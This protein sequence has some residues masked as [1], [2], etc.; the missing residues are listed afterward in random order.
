MAEVCWAPTEKGGGL[1]TESL[2]EGP[3]QE[4]SYYVLSISL[5]T[6]DQT[7]YWEM[8]MQ[9]LRLQTKPLHIPAQNLYSTWLETI[10]LELVS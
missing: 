2:P 1:A 5:D 9:N 7:Q 10:L 6:G 4:E 8:H 3:V